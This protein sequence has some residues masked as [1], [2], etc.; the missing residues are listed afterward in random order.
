MRF[1][2]GAL[3]RSSTFSWAS[4]VAWLPG[5]NGIGAEPDAGAADDGVAADMIQRRRWC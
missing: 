1:R 2:V 3:M 5:P 4:T